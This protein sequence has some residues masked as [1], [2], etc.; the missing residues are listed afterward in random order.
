V[1][2]SRSGPPGAL[3]LLLDAGLEHRARALADPPV[4]RDL[5]DVETDHERRV[6]RLAGPE[7]V[8]RRRERLADLGELER[9][10]DAAAVVRVHRRGRVRI[11]PREQRVRGLGTR[12][13]VMLRPALASTGRRRRGERE[14]HEGCTEIEPGASYD[15]GRMARGEDFVDRGVGEWRVRPDRGLPVER[16]DPDEPGG[17]GRLVRQDRQA[18]VDL[19]RVG[20]HQLGRNPL[21]QSLRDGGLATRGRAEDADN[22]H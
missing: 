19:H 4:Q 13:V 11:E 18:S 15:H 1:P 5:R 17:I 8:A 6:P 14:L 16:P 9:T 21:C 12:L 10:D 7:P 3:D 22:R 2:S 20:R